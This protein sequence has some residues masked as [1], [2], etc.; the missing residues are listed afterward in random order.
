LSKAKIVAAKLDFNRLRNRAMI[1]ELLATLTH[2]P[3][4][5]LSYKEVQEK[6][7]LQGGIYRGLQDIPLDKIVGSVG[8][9]RDFTRTFLPRD[10]SDRERWAHVKALVEGMMGLPPIEVFQVGDV[11]FVKDGNHRVSV[12]QEMGAQT[13][14]THVTECKS[15][16]PLDADVT[17]EDLIVKADYAT[18]LERTRLDELRPEQ[19]IEFSVP[20]RYQDLLT[21]IGAH[22]HY[23]EQ[24]LGQPVP[25]EEAVTGWYDNVYL[26]LVR[27]IGEK[28]LLKEFPH[29]TEADLYAWVTRYE[30]E[31]GQRYDTSNVDDEVI[32]EEFSGLYS[33]RPVIAQL[34]AMRRAC[35]KLFC[36]KGSAVRCMPG[37]KS[38][39]GPR[40]SLR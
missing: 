39:G 36:R 21:H 8:R 26:P 40:V 17:P 18:F 31:L 19:R 20:G 14:Q 7:H 2:A 28:G 5:L 37:R 38:T 1:Q 34:K 35:R 27:L 30:M 11:Y 33:E 3:I 15:P 13:I 29:R 6:L 23:L 22:Q 16:V 32:V 10:N 12:A 25:W 9:Y 4:D 24:R